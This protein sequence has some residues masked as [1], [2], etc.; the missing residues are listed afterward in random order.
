MISSFRAA[1]Q[2][3]FIIPLAFV[4]K[5][6]TLYRPFNPEDI[7]SCIKSTIPSIEESVSVRP[8][9]NMEDIKRK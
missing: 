1:T 9:I 3:E 5:D 8:V 4:T 2:R 7:Q 6:F